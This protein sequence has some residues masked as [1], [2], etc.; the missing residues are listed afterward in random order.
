MKRHLKVLFCYICLSIASLLSYDCILAGNLYLDVSFTSNLLWN[1]YDVNLFIDGE[2]IDTLPHGEDYSVFLENLEDGEHQLLFAKSDNNDINGL[3]QFSM[4]GDTTVQCEISC[5]KKEINIS[6]INTIGNTDLASLSVPDM[7]GMPLLAA[8][9][10]LSE[11][12][13]VN[14]KAQAD[15]GSIHSEGNWTVIEQSIQSGDTAEKNEEIELTCIKTQEYLEECA[16]CS[17]CP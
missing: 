10:S 3:L 5:D 4:N 12:G 2:E 7:H 14:V 1:K 15:E 8:Q 9:K 13:F 6:D 11:I 16:F 17:P